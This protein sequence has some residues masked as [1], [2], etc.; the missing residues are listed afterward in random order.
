MEVNSMY[1]KPEGGSKG[2][3]FGTFLDTLKRNE[4]AQQQ[5]PQ[6]TQQSTPPAAA[7]GANVSDTLPNSAPVSDNARI[8]ILYI[9]A[10]PETK[11]LSSADLLMASGLSLED[12]TPALQRLIDTGLVAKTAASGGKKKCALTTKGQEYAEALF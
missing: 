2:N 9:L 5:Q 6:Q 4:Q 12:F 10:Q 7:N 8:N 3:S 1:S 11:S